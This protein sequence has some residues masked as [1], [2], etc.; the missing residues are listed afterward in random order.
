MLGQNF[1]GAGP[2]PI[3][4]S[5]DSMKFFLEH[6]MKYLN[7]NWSL[8]LLHPVYILNCAK[9]QDH[10]WIAISAVNS[11]EINQLDC[12]PTGTKTMYADAHLQLKTWTSLNQALS[13]TNLGLKIHLEMALVVALSDDLGA[14]QFRRSDVKIL[15]TWVLTS[16]DE[17]QSVWLF[18]FR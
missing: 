2:W 4:G 6:S 10:N 18:S 9:F 8:N 1:S 15:I 14:V 13:G 12:I 17:V 7:Y 3:F 16:D 11:K 5:N